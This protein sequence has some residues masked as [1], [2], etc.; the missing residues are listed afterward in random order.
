MEGRPRQAGR[1]EQYRR[2]RSCLAERLRQNREDLVLRG[3]PLDHRWTFRLP[4]APDERTSGRFS[5]LAPCQPRSRMAW[6]NMVS[7]MA[8][9]SSL[10]NWRSEEHTSELQSPC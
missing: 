9:M 4:T 3:R 7:P 1:I 6:M 5:V 8:R 10:V 2:A